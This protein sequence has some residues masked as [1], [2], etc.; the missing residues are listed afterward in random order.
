MSRLRVHSFAISLDGY[1]A[2]PNHD[3]ANPLGVF[4]LRI[5]AR[6]ELSQEGGERVHRQVAG[7]G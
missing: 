7:V 5:H 6:S 2:G 1:G 4:S 3:L